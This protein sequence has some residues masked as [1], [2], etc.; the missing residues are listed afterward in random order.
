M[1]NSQDQQ[2]LFQDLSLNTPQHVPYQFFRHNFQ[3]NSKNPSLGESS[4]RVTIDQPLDD[5][6]A[7]S[8]TAAMKD[9]LFQVIYQDNLNDDNHM[10][11]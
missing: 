6:R 8:A 11:C 2:K 5:R 9:P 4:T 7:I 10:L 3:G 1:Q